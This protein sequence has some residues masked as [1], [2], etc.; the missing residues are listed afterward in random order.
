MARK[1]EGL[2]QAEIAHL[3]PA[4]QAQIRAQL[5]NTLPASIV[6]PAF[7]R[8]RTSQRRVSMTPV[9]PV[10]RPTEPQWWEGLPWWQGLCFPV[11]AVLL[12]ILWHIL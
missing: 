2:T 10:E 8:T 7:R 1:V 4:A 5:H 12:L 11:G 9:A 6:H 3:S